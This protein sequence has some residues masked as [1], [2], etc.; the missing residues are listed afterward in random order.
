MKTFSR[1]FLVVLV[2]VANS[3][4]YG[5]ISVRLLKPFTNISND[6]NDGG[7]NNNSSNVA[8]TRS[9]SWT[10]TSIPIL[11]QTDSSIPVVQRTSSVP[12]QIMADSSVPVVQ[13][14][15]SLVPNQI[16]THSVQ[17]SGFGRVIKKPNKLNL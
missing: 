14:K 8:S 9:H 7:V 3:S 2:V 12:N 1:V 5:W 11:T 4:Y 15:T 13:R 10:D 16:V 6:N 17:R